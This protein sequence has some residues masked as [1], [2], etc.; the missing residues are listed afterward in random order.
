MLLPLPLPP[1]QLLLSVA[2]TAAFLW[3]VHTYLYLPWRLLSHYRRLGLRG[4]A[5]RPLLGDIPELLAMRSREDEYFHLAF[6]EGAARYGP[7]SFTFLGPELR[8]RAL[9]LTFVRAV[10]S[11]TSGLWRKPE[12]MRAT[13]GRLLGSG[14]VTSEGAL[15]R[16][17]RAMISPAFNWAC[18]AA[19]APMMVRAADAG[20]ERWLSAAA[21]AAAG[22]SGVGT[23]IDMHHEISAIT[24]EIIGEAA[25]GGDIVDAKGA[26][27]ADAIYA[28]VEELLAIVVRN[29]LNG[30]AFIPFADYLP[31][32][33]I[34]RSN[35][36]CAEVKAILLDVIARRRSARA[37]K[38]GRAHV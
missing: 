4:P 19:L 30:V 3:A 34:V 26:K 27:Q 1:A 37:G 17:H 2:C 14:L 10:L 18:L 5:W 23:L 35:Q 22:G 33:D 7:V 24:L 6:S 25:F 15:H 28:A 32:P 8:L 20:L 31:I 21:A 16:A 29:V 38:I 11:D 9:D 13:M 12:L 36:K